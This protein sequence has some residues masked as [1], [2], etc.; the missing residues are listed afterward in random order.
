MYTEGGEGI[1]C[2][3]ESNDHPGLPPFLLVTGIPGL[4]GGL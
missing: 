2:I 1:V 3:I 4:F